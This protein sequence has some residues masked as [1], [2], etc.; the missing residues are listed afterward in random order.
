[1]S[2]RVVAAHTLGRRRLG[3]S[4]PEV[5]VVGIGTNNFGSRLDQQGAERV[6]MAAL[7]HG[8]NLFDTADIYPE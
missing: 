5:S 4:G 3:K 1:M 2:D 6:V 8:V 7:D